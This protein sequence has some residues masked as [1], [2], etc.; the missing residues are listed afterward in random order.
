VSAPPPHDGVPQLARE[1]RGPLAELLG[2]G[3]TENPA[4]R[5]DRHPNPNPCAVLDPV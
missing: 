1:N 2:W 5:A 3:L 4:E